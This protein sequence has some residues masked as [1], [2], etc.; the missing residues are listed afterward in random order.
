[1]R[2]TMP[3]R[4]TP[5]IPDSW[6]RQWVK[7]GID[8]RSVRI[9]CGGVDDEAGRLVDH[10]QMLVF[11]NHRKRDL[12]RDGFGSRSFRYV[13]GERRACDD[14]ERGLGDR[15]S[16]ETNPSFAQQRLDSFARQPAGVGERLVQPSARL[17]HEPFDDATGIDCLDPHCQ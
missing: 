12:L 5:P 15:R 3:G 14:L 7:Q 9:A 4:A 2:C 6:P 17:P 13:D 11:E 1:M 8:E 10:D 16:G